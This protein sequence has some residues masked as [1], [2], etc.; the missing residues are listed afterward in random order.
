MG[1]ATGTPSTKAAPQWNFRERFSPPSADGADSK[2]DS[3]EKFS[4]PDADKE[5]KELAERS[6]GESAYSGYRGLLANEGRHNHT[7]FTLGQGL[8]DY[9]ERTD[10]QTTGVQDFQAEGKR[11]AQ[12]DEIASAQAQRS[13]DENAGAAPP[14]KKPQSGGV[15][16]V[17]P[18]HFRPVNA[19]P[20]SDLY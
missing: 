4:V 14:R 9:N 3:P 2:P 13:L 17:G 10:T 7:T 6:Q 11:Q 18:T 8:A 19:N 15:H 12:A 1:K 5:L 20:D 16:I